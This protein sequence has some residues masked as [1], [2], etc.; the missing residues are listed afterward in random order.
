[1][2][3]NLSASREYGLQQIGL[4]SSLSSATSVFERSFTLMFTG[5][6]IDLQLQP[7]PIDDDSLRPSTVPL[8][9]FQF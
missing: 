3:E 8:A 6:L 2:I 1:L 4:L 9:Q 5:Q 7:Q